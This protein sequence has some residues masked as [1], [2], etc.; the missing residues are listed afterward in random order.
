[1][2]KNGK[3]LSGQT[4]VVKVYGVPN[5][6]A[7]IR[8]K[9]DQ[10]GTAFVHVCHGLEHLAHVAEIIGH[11]AKTARTQA[12]LSAGPVAYAQD[13]PQHGPDD[14]TGC[15]HFEEGDVDV[16]VLDAVGQGGN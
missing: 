13:N 12:I 8:G 6:A 4:F 16:R 2:S 1:M 11:F 9:T 3:S 14:G 7:G 5:D 15:W 10:P